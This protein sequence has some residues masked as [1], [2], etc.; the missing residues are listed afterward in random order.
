MLFLETNCLSKGSSFKVLKDRIK[1]MV[2]VPV[3]GLVS[4]LVSMS[5]RVGMRMSSVRI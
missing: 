2:S 1:V 3:T 4:M 5:V